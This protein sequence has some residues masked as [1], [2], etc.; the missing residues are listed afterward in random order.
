[1]TSHSNV[2]VASSEA[3]NVNVI[4]NPRE[5]NIVAYIIGSLGAESAKDLPYWRKA[6]QTLS[7]AQI[8]EAI[9]IAKSKKPRGIA[10][11]KYATGVMRNMMAACR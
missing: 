10:Q 9:E 8:A 6:A 1:M 2:N 7:E 3:S 5:R 4:R 11:I